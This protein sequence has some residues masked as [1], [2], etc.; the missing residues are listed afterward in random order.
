M[1]PA[2]AYPE[3]IVLL[4]FMKDTEK[5]LMHPCISSLFFTF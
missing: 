2:G 5:E 3:E 1:D 4:N